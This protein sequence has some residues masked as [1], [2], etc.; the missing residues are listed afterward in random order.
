MQSRSARW[1]RRWPRAIQWTA[2][3]HRRHHL[4]ERLCIDVGTHHRPGAILRRG[5]EQQHAARA[6]LAEPA[7]EEVAPM[8]VAAV[9]GH[10]ERHGRRAIGR[11]GYIE[12]EAAAL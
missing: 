2:S 1:W 6:C 8:A 10:D 12:R 9:E 3:G 4:A 7:P 11:L 5:R